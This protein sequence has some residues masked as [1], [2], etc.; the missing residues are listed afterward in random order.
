MTIYQISGSYGEINLYPGGAFGDP[1]T[2][3]ST[4]VVSGGEFGVY[5]SSVWTIANAGAVSGGS[6]GV[7]LQNGGLVTNEAS[8]TITGDAGVSL[9]GA[10][11]TVGNYGKIY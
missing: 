7:V 8:G 3:M 4:G 5:A 10:A 11:G 1:L 2:V 6:I 9:A